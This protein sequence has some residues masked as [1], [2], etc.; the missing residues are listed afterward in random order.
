[1]ARVAASGPHQREEAGVWP[2]GPARPLL[3]A[4]AVHLWRADLDALPDEL[5][6]LLSRAEQA[7]ADRLLSPHRRLLWT[8]ARGLLR[9]LLGIYLDKDP[10]AVRLVEAEHGK[11]A[12]L[13]GRADPS[14]RRD[15]SGSAQLSFNLSHSGALALYGFTNDGPIG[16]DVEL[17]ARR[18]FD[19]LALAARAFGSSEAQRLRSL[20]PA[21]RQQEFLRLWTRH[22]AA[23]KCLG[24]GIGRHSHGAA[25][26]GELWTSELDLGAR[27]LGA[28]A[29]TRSPQEIERW[30]WQGLDG[31]GLTYSSSA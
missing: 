22:E 31:R 6:E 8:R 1:M 26:R 11:P 29:L 20:H 10:R 19:H 16:V 23:L 13:A 14:A 21:S 5:G 25:G 17:A 24:A 12:L 30:E 7:R 28:L 4:G 15:R 2:R 3:A 9:A 18:E 27:A